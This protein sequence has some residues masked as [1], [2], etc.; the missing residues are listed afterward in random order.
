MKKVRDFFFPMS[1]FGFLFAGLVFM[2]VTS[3]RDPAYMPQRTTFMGREAVGQLH[4]D[5]T[6]SYYRI[7]TEIDGV[8]VFGPEDLIYNF[9]VAEAAKLH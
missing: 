6:Y 8:A 1:L 3:E 9:P 2:Y 5:G 7:K 4:R